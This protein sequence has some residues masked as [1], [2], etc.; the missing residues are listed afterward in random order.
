M[1]IA[2]ERQEMAFLMNF[3]KYPVIGLDMS[4]RPFGEESE[5]M[6]GSKVRVAW[7]RKRT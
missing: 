7:D 6:V 2:F 4:N 1:K 3:G 5:F